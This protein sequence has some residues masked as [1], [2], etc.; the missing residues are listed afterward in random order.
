[1]KAKMFFIKIGK[2]ILFLLIA[3]IVLKLSYDYLHPDKK[4]RVN[5]GEAIEIALNGSG[6]AWQDVYDVETHLDWQG[7][8]NIPCYY[9]R[10]KY[11]DESGQEAVFCCAVDGELWEYLGP[12]NWT[13]F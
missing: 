8:G 9:I 5:R 6:H 4:L 2:L 3:A 7:S 11:L 1:M 10:F 13:I 12:A